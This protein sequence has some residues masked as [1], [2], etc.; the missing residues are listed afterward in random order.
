MVAELS[1]LAESA[2]DPVQI[3]VGL[4]SNTG[5][6]ATNL[7]LG[8]QGLATILTDLKCSSVFETQPRYVIDQAPFLNACC[9]G[10]TMVTDRQL[11]AALQDLERKAGR[12]TGGQ[13]YGPRALDLDLLLYDE[14][15]I[16]ES[17]LVVPH[18]RLRER[19]FVLV[20]L[21]EV[22]A[23]WTVPASQ[24]VEDVTVG[25]L[26]RRVGEEGIVRTSIQIH[27]A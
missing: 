22:A 12:K 23:D 19:A 1:G 6:R 4:G 26:A 9:I 11:M 5:C 2:R 13:R 25:E 14:S 3:A 17:D 7:Q 24:G 21:A 16:E 27:P 8:V 10:R 15:V 20:P 18:P